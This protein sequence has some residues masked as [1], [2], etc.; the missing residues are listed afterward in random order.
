MDFDLALIGQLSSVLKGLRGV[1]KVVETMEK[2]KKL[3]DAAQELVKNKAF[4]KKG[5]YTIPIPLAGG[6]VH[7]WVGRKYAETIL[8]GSG[9][10]LGV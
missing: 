1:G 9:K 7:V 10:G 5:V 6:G 8:V 4:I 2:Y 3:S